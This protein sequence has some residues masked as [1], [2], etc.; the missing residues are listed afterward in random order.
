MSTAQQSLTLATVL[1]LWS[2]ER[3][4]F[5][6]E[7]SGGA[8]VQNHVAVHQEEHESAEVRVPELCMSTAH[9]FSTW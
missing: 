5:G 7:R 1:S 3:H 4:L 6:Q 2:G 8:D 9:G